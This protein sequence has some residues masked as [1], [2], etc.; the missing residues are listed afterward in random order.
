[1]R[2]SIEEYVNEVEWKRLCCSLKEYCLSLLSAAPGFLFAVPQKV[3]AY[4]QR[5]LASVCSI[6]NVENAAPNCITQ[7]K[8]KFRGGMKASWTD[9][10]IGK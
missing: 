10:N 6:A 8:V 5:K 1:M 7:G 3:F 2:D 9:A 4:A